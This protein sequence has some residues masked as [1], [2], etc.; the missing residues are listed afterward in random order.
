MLKMHRTMADVMKV[1]GSR[2][3]RPDGRHRQHAR[4]RRRRRDAEPGAD[5]GAREEDAGW[6]GRAGWAADCRRPCRGCRRNSPAA[7]RCCPALAARS[8]AG[9]P[10]WEE[11][12]SELPGSWSRRRRT[13]NDISRSTEDRFAPTRSTTTKGKPMSLKIR[14]ARAGTKK[15]PVYHIVVADSRS[16]RDGRFIERLGYLQSAAAE[17][18]DRAAEV[19]RREGQGLDGQ[20][21]DA[22]PTACRASSTRPA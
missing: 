9:C 17:G 3:A 19:R 21:R 7:V 4:P 20:G 18:E 10:D 16:P 13:R 6:R 14:L 8:R 2:Q 5:G 12:M 22:R 15:R 11:E 1:M